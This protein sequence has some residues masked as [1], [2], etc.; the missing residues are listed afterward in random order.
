MYNFKYI[1][2]IYFHIFLFYIC[3]FSVYSQ[4]PKYSNDFLS[5]GVGARALA[6]SNSVSST[7]NDVTAGYWNPAG[8]GKLE[9]ERQIALMHNEYFA[10]IAKYDYGAI[11][12]KTG[13]SGGLSLSVIRVGVDDI[14]NTLYFIDSEGNFNYDKITSFSAVGYGFF[15]SYGHANTKINGLRYGATA[16]VIHNKAGYFAS[17]WG[18]GIDFG[19]Q[20]E[21]NNWMFGL[22]GRDIT[23]TFNA[24]KYD[25]TDEDKAQLTLLG[26]TVP[27]N[28]LEITL[29]KLIPGI[30]RKINLTPKIS[31][32]VALDADITFDRK[33]NVMIASNPVSIDP[34][35]GLEVS[36]NKIIFLRAGFG[37]FQHL[38][39]NA[40]KRVSSYQINM[41]VGVNIMKSISIDYTL[42]DLGD[43]S[44]SLY[45]NVFSLKLCFNKPKQKTKHLF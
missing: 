17:S 7:T 31:C 40:N 15:L 23:T 1:K 16:K 45:S 34:H 9:N 28:S 37:N 35:A 24:W 41:G 14:P 10:G 27:E 12:A 5:I 22:M 19:L 38:T 3:C 42:T 18:F 21:L 11:A 44:I 4:I 36:Y 2:F 20:Y 30:A 33:R 25:F 6:M 43:R 39:N 29:P 26:N 32:L 13:T 8:L